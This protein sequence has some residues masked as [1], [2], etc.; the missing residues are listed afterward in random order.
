MLTIDSDINMV[1]MDYLISEGYPG[2][3]EKFA[4]E[5]NVAQE[6]AIDIDAIKERVKIRD[7]IYSGNMQEAIVLLNELNPE[8]CPSYHTPDST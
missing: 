3:A 7:A 6:E 2:A 8:V 1:I 4:E 5:T